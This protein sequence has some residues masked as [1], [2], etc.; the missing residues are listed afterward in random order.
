MTPHIVIFEEVSHAIKKESCDKIK[1]S[2]DPLDRLGPVQSPVSCPVV[3]DD[4]KFKLSN[5][6]SL[7]IIHDTLHSNSL[8]KMI[9]STDTSV[10]IPESCVSDSSIRHE[11]PRILP[12]R[13]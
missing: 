9:F 10:F 4:V 8:L 7:D 1:K 5:L 2:P 11:R 6:K 12:R 13:H 3:S